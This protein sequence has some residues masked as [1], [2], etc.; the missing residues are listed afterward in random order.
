M[1]KKNEQKLSVAVSNYLKLAYPNVVFTCDS[2]GV[3]LSIGQAVALKKQRSRH[4]IP[5]ML[6]LEPSANGVYHFMVL[7]LKTIEANPYL[8]NGSLSSSEHIQE[9]NKTLE[10]LRSK[11]AYAEFAVGLDDAIK[12]IDNYLH[13]N[14]TTIDLKN[15]AFSKGA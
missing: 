5:D 2:S 9:Q 13:K 14:T 7:E 15:N 4:K 6:I 3:K 8:K 1:A 11:G 12:K 10:L